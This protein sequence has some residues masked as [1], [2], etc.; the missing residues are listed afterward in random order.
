MASS[1]YLRALA[2]VRTRGWHF[3]VIPFAYEKPSARANVGSCV[4]AASTIVG[5]VFLAGQVVGCEEEEEANG[6][7][8]TCQTSWERTARYLGALRNMT[9]GLDIGGT[10][11]KLAVLQRC[12]NSDK[13]ILS[14]EKFGFSGHRVTA[15]E[16]KCPGLGGLGKNTMGTVHFIKWNTA[17]TGEALEQ[18]REA[19]P[20]CP[21]M[22]NMFATGGGAYRFAENIRKTLGWNFQKMPEFDALVEGLRFIF[23]NLP[24]DVFCIE[25]DGTRVPAEFCH[26]CFRS[27]RFPVLVCNIGTGVSMI[28]VAS[29]G[30]E[31]VGGTSIGGST[32]L[33]L[34]YQLTG[35]TNFTD[36]MQ[37]A[38]EGDG[39]EVDLLVRDIYGNQSQDQ[40]GLNGDLTASS[41]GRLTRRKPGDPKPSDGAMAASVCNFVTQSIALYACQLARR[42]SCREVIFTGGFLEDNEIAQRRLSTFVE[43]EYKRGEG[44]GRALFLHHAEYAGALGCLSRQIHE[45][46]QTYGSTNLMSK[47]STKRTIG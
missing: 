11:A 38:Q 16:V 4:A 36:A 40:L 12:G 14:E 18:I 6:W 21:I 23:D 25:K 8:R 46:N 35:A 5:V 9:C 15:M 44:H 43:N 1:L 2:A 22:A 3:Y 45:E 29:D 34:T 31:R 19:T 47:R 41:F 7:K 27:G 33:G 24:D 32:F 10:T 42:H 13:H 28:K 20:E 26:G 30:E 17:D 39:S 37:L